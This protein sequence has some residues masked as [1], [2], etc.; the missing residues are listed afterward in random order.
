MAAVIDLHHTAATVS[1]LERSIAFYSDLL[2]L[3][4]LGTRSLHAEEVYRL[5]GLQ[6]VSAQYAWLRVGRAGIL[7][8]FEFDP[9][10][11]TTAVFR[12]T[13]AGH[14]F[15]S[16]QVR[17]LEVLYR[18]LIRQG[19]EGMTPPR[20]IHAGVQIAF[21][22]DPD[23]L[24]IELTDLGMMVTPMVKLF[25]GVLGFFERFKRR[26]TRVIPTGACRNSESK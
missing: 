17:H 2:G 18:D 16:F 20:T 25:G 12:P 3:D 13:R 19:V 10:D 14:Q 1:N 5:F 11:K 21:I 26:R 9:P 4:P 22:K 7:E 8:L 23:G 24:V 15:I 6:G